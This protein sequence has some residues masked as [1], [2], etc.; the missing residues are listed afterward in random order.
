M[1]VCNIHI[2]RI[3]NDTHLEIEEQG[4]SEEET[5]EFPDNERFEG[6]KNS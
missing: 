1:E 4:I 3:A 2:D 5:L 6:N